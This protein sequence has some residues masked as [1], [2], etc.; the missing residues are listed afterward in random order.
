LFYEKFSFTKYG[1]SRY[2]SGSLAV[3][4]K[5]RGEPASEADV[6]RASPKIPSSRNSFLFGL[7]RRKF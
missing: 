2:F 6:R 4:N 7:A 1:S 5:E 3:F